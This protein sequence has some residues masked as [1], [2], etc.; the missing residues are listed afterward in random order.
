VAC[1][2]VVKDSL[3]MREVIEVGRIGSLAYEKLSPGKRVRKG[4]REVLEGIL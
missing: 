1:W 3:S 2:P 4:R